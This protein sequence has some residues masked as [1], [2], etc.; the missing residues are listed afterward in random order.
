MDDNFWSQLSG[1]SAPNPLAPTPIPMGDTSSPQPDPASAGPVSAPPTAPAAGESDYDKILARYEGDEAKARQ[2]PEYL[3]AKA[4]RDKARAKQNELV[5]DQL[6]ALHEISTSPPPNFSP[7]VKEAAPEMRDFGV[8]ALPWLMMMSAIGGKVAGLSGMNMLG[9]M[10]GMMM[11]AQNG[12][13]EAFDQAYTN[14]GENWSRAQQDWKNRMAL[15]NAQ[16]DWRKGKANAEG[17]A[18]QAERE[19]GGAYSD[20]MKQVLGFHNAQAKAMVQMA[21]LDGKLRLQKEKLDQGD[22]KR[23]DDEITKYQKAA[24]AFPRL[25][26]AKGD[27]DRALKLLPHVLE[28]YK[29]DT[30]N[31]PNSL[32]PKTFAEYLVSTGD[33]EVQQFSSYMKS[34]KPILA[35]LETSGTGSRSNML[36]QSM[37]ADTVPTSVFNLGAAQVDQLTRDATAI[38][39][40][41]LQQQKQNIALWAQRLSSHGIKVPDQPDY[42]IPPSSLPSE[43]KGESPAPASGGW[44]KATVVSD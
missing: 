10:K 12:Q 14:W 20:D 42:E 33:T 8:Q 28:K 21:A 18:A 23:I 27:A 3:A 22:E 7:P 1:S 9:A 41:S 26:A 16:L 37:I 4:G 35:A 43:R 5:D 24:A 44:G 34:A 36:L 19:L 40:T 32:A 38:L 11:G 25:Q 29:N 31:G 39:D 30:E 2:D 15:Y 13:K 6:K 17:L